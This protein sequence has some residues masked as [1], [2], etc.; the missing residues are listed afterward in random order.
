MWPFDQIRARRDDR[1][2]SAALVVLLGHY[3]Y[4]RLNAADRARIDKEVTDNLR[5][6]TWHVPSNFWKNAGWAGIAVERALAM[7]R[8]RIE[9]TAHGVT[10]EELLRRFPSQFIGQREGLMLDYWPQKPPPWD[11]RAGFVW[12]NFRPNDA[13]TSR[14]KVFL[15]SNGLDVPETDPKERVQGVAV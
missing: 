13:A 4:A 2:F 14:A 11:S 10:W 12:P 1:R 15:R 7:A 9:P 3:F 8:L 6:D 5:G